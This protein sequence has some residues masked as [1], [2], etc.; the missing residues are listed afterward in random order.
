MRP[1]SPA[2]GWRPRS[3][4]FGGKGVAVVGVVDVET[5]RLTVQ[6][7]GGLSAGERRPN[8]FR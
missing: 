8:G 4:F 6:G 3:F 7:I 1:E 2:C 5:V